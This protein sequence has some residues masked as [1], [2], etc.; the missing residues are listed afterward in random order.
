MALT[1]VDIQH[2]QFKTAFKGY[3][4]G[5]VDEFVRNVSEALEE[6]LKQKSDMQH[7]IDGL[8]AE[9][10]R[11]RKIE[12]AMTN[13]LMLAQKSADELRAG[14]HRQAEMILQEAEQSRVRMTVEA[15][16]HAEKYR[17][18]IALLSATKDRF[19]SEFRAI[20][21]GYME[22]LER[23]KTGDEARAEVA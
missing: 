9:V 22:W 17:T 1:P 12:T 16:T 7:Q 21:S 10:D 4:K 14:A 13:A 8:Q 19:E 2:I 3:N 20:L 15:Q 18:E 23:R 5:S 11:V 6:A